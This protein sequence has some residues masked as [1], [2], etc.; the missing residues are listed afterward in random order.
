MR[1]SLWVS[2]K[3][4]PI[5]IEVCC[6]RLSDR[7]CV[8]INVAKTDVRSVRL[9]VSGLLVVLA[10]RLLLEVGLPPAEAV[11][12]PLPSGSL[13]QPSPFF[14]ACDELEREIG[15]DQAS[16]AAKN[17]T[18][19]ALRASTLDCESGSLRDFILSKRAAQQELP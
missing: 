19:N 9:C 14:F 10:A 13:S 18:E 11:S 8:K 17:Q 1:L 6:H 7:K 2:N 5:E 4:L 15:K 16:L 12:F 3:G